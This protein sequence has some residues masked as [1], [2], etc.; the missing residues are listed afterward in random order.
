[1][2]VLFSAWELKGRYPAILEHPKYGKAARDLYDS[3]QV[4][5]DRIVGERLLT[6][7]GVYGFW[8]AAS[9]DDDIVIYRDVEHSGELVRFNLL[10]QQEAIADGKANLSLADFIAPRSALGG[11]RTTTSAPSP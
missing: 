9:E 10:R 3:A 11:G 7:R 2:D 4:M 1:L 5:L 6:A 8:P